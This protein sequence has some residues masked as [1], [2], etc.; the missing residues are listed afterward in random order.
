MIKHLIKNRNA[1][2]KI[3]LIG[4]E[5]NF[6]SEHQLLNGSILFIGLIYLTTVILNYLSGLSFAVTIINTIVTVIFVFIYYL[7]RFKGLYKVPLFLFYSSIYISLTIDW[8][9]ACG[10]ISSMPYYY[11]AFICFIVFF[12]SGTYRIILVILYIL[13][14]ALLFYFEF[15]YPEIVTPYPSREVQLQDMFESFLFMVFLIIYIVYSR[16]KLYLKEKQNTIDIIEQYRNSS[17]KLKKEYNEKFTLLSIRER[18]VFQLIIEG[19]SNKEIAGKLYITKETVKQHI[20]R[21]FKKIGTKSR[22][23]TIDIASFYK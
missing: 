2:L 7:A 16:K 1:S 20:N 9:F 18:E 21:I 11:L 4:N 23:D 15:N 6:T 3:V 22:K 14:I 13:D 12:S 5:I 19:M 17:E 10:L 8:F